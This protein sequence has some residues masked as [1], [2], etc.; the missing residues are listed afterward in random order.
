MIILL[1][2][3]FLAGVVTVV[4]PCILPVLPLLLS[5]ADGGHRRP[6][7][8]VSGLVCSF[9]FFT[10]ALSALVQTTGIS[11]DYLRYAALGLIIFF[12]LTMLFP[13][14]GERLETWMGG[15]TRLGSV[16][17]GES[18]NVGSGFWGGFVLGCALGLLWSPCAGPILATITTLVATRAIAWSTILLTAAYSIGSAIPMLLIMYGGNVMLNSMKSIE[19]YTGIIRRLF[20]ALMIVGALLI[21]FHGDTVLQHLVEN[22]LPSINIENNELV[23]KELAKLKPMS[24]KNFSF[25]INPQAPE[26]VG[27]N[28]WINSPA[29]DLKQLRGRVVLLDFWTY[30]CINCVR[31]LPYLK[32]WYET[33]KDK[34]FTIIGVHTPE[35]EFEKSLENVQNAVHRFGIQYPVALDNEYKTWQNYNNHYWP[36]HYLIDQNGIVK[37]QRFGEGGYEETENAIRHLLGLS[38]L[39]LKK[40][41][42]HGNKSITPEIYLGY[43]RASNYQYEIVIKKDEAAQYD[44]H[45]QLGPDRVGLKGSWLIGPQSITA[46]SDGALLNLNFSANR[47]YLVMESPSE[48]Q[49]MV[50]LD[51]QPVPAKYFTVDMTGQ[52][53]IR[54]N[55]SRMYDIL[56]LKGDDDGRHVLTLQFPPGVSAYA[57]T[58]GAELQ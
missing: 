58:F 39:V 13:D 17:Q 6:W 51:G 5:A 43:Q 15:L 28:H 22:Y 33:Y 11:P 8:I 53:A 32:Q 27:I 36:A 44:Y 9:T 31:T 7:G 26:L 37:E 19:G 55:S 25:S 52:G 40:A 35:F 10:L 3:A 16:V 47:A 21:G 45:G 42:Q 12:G 46:K 54:V 41:E 2:F 20:G 48:Q 49:V 29:L 18:K 34:G 50:L 30:S 1:V 23:K 24:N 14:F 56:D 38:P 57:Y 4:S